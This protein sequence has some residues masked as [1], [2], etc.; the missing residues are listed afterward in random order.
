MTGY[1]VPQTVAKGEL[2]IG[3]YFE[4]DLLLDTKASNLSPRG[5]HAKSEAVSSFAIVCGIGIP[6]VPS[7]PKAVK[8]VRLSYP[9]LIR[10]CKSG[11][12]DTTLA[13]KFADKIGM[14]FGGM[15]VPGVAALNPQ[16]IAS[17]PPGCF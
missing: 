11:D 9:A 13:D 12:C 5:L 15:K 14:F 8:R 2:L 16:L 3:C 1:H 7:L 10:F 17:I 4:I 6:V